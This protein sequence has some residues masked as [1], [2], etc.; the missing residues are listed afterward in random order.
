[1]GAGAQGEARAGSRAVSCGSRVESAA[2]GLHRAGGDAAPYSR[3]GWSPALSVGPAGMGNRQG[4]G[5]ARAG[6]CLLL[7]SLQLLPRMQAGEPGKGK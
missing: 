3:P 6:L 4:P 2:E 7:A 5:Q 1:M